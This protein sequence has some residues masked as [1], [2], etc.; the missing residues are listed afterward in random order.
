MALRAE[1]TEQKLVA[2][3]QDGAP[4]GEEWRETWPRFAGHTWFDV[5]WY[6]AEAYFFRRLLEAAHYFRPGPWERVDPYRPQKLGELQGDGGALARF[7]AALS[8]LPA[9]PESCL[10]DLLLFELWGNRADLSF[11]SMAETAY[12]GL[13]SSQTAGLLIDQRSPIWERLKTGMGQLDFVNDNAG[14]ELLFDLALADFALRTGL[15]RRV[16]FHLKSQP[17]FVSDTMIP[18]VHEALEQMEQRPAL[19]NLVKRLRAA[20][21]A[22]RFSLLTDPFWVTARGFDQMPANL[23]ADLS[24]AD[25]VIFKGDAN[26]R[27][28]LDD[29]AWPVAASLSALTSYLPFSFVAIRSIKAPLAV[30]LTD[31]LVARLDDSDAEWMFNGQYG[32]IQLVSRR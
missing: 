28:L 14:L 13:D 29:R 27:R 9:K 1:L 3:L 20:L 4:D 5:P 12:A 26:Y 32:L 16:R 22:D 21:A 25:L 8:Q 15:A 17:F 2:G 24:R 18:D 30:D 19:G 6:P 7:E 23:R 31:A 10:H 11:D